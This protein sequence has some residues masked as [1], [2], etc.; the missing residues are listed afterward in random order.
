M[1]P[2]CQRMVFI[3]NPEDRLLPDITGKEQYGTRDK[4]KLKIK[5][6]DKNGQPIQADF[7]VS[8]TDDN[9]VYIDSL[10]RNSLISDIWL[11]SD[12][13]GYVEDP[14]YYFPKQMTEKIWHDLDNLLLTQGWVTFSRDT[15]SPPQ[16]QAEQVFSIN[17]TVTNILNKPVAGSQVLLFSKK[18]FLLKETV[19]HADGAFS[20]SPLYP[21]DT[22]SFMLQAR[23]KRGKS[24]NVGIRVNAFKPPVLKPLKLRTTPWYVNIDTTRDDII[25]TQVADQ[26]TVDKL[27]GEHVLKEVV[28]VGQ[29]AIPGS[30]NLNGPGGSD[31][32]LDQ[33]DMEK[34]GKA[35]L[36]DIL[37]QK[38]KGFRLGGKH[39]DRYLIHTELVHLIIDGVN[40]DFFKPEN[41]SYKDFYRSYLDYITAEDI[42]GIEVM[43]SARYTGAY[44]QKFLHPMDK[45]FDHAFIE[46]TTYS[47][48]GAFLK[49]TPG[50]FLYKP[51]VAFNTSAHFYSPKYTVKE[52]KHLPDLRSTIYW[53]PDIVTNKDGE[54]EISF[55]TADKPGTYTLI[56]EG[57]DMNGDIGSEMKKIEVK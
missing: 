48:N 30:K 22:A 2:V 51:P 16:F 21:V 55:Y 28:I 7:S 5:V 39:L 42:K 37:R 57:T 32:V 33:S 3:T 35:T 29:K 11:T 25:Q 24:F 17:G 23:N 53:N 31:L 47:G 1:Q 6:S 44:F 49:K 46:I 20:F 8:V 18:P 10:K 41:A 14:G 27:L 4:V 40:L 9:K 52:E 13:R 54:A 43:Y 45:P 12:L 26:E 50:V 56:L 19:T 38:V 36:R 15:A 34:E